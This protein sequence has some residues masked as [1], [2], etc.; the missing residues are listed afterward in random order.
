L[1]AHYNTGR[2]Y[3]DEVLADA[4]AAYWRLGEA[5]GTTAKEGIG[6]R[7]GTYTNG[8][9]LAQT[10]AP[11]GDP[12]TAVRFDGVDDRVRVPYSSALNPSAF[13]LEAWAKP[14]GG[15]GTWRAVVGSWK[16]PGDF[17]YGIWASDANT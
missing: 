13:T 6:G 1:R 8:P 15:Q 9:T 11:T 2:C 12:D 7:H 17:G 14:T 4:P 3:K 10:G 16:Q 5:S